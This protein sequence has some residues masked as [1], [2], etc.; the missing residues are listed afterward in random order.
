F[1]P[2]VKPM[3]SYNEIQIAVAVDVD[4]H[5]PVPPAL[6]PRQTSVLRTVYQFSSLINEYANGHVFTDNNKVF[7][8]ITVYVSPYSIRYHADVRQVRRH[9]LANIHDV[10]RPIILQNIA[11]SR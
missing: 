1:E 9:L 8:A 6:A 7:I 3:I 2:R 11:T 5:N 10:S 4:R